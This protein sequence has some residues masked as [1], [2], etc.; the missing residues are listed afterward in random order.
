MELDDETSSN[1][2]DLII[3]ELKNFYYRTKKQKL[4]NQIKL[5]SLKYQEKFFRDCIHNGKSPNPSLVDKYHL[6]AETSSQS[7]SDF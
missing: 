7:F 1:K 2:G 5:N 6:V 3:T 4:F